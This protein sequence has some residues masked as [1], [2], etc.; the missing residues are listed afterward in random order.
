MYRLR[1]FRSLD[2]LVDYYRSN[3]VTPNATLLLKDPNIQV[4]FY[5]FSPATI[6]LL[7]GSREPFDVSM[8]GKIRCTCIAVLDENLPKISKK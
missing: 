2:T 3:T 7:F 1:K 5:S 6:A 8:S 4:N